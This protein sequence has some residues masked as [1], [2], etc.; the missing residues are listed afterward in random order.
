MA[1]SPRFS[2]EGDALVFWESTSHLTQG[3]LVS[4]ANEAAKC[5]PVLMPVVPV[6][7]NAEVTTQHGP[8]PLR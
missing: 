6:I 1:D 2:A 8:R 3:S 4:A 5:M 7:G